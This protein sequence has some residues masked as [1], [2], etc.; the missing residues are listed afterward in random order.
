DLQAAQLALAGHGDGDEAAAGAAF[1]EEVADVLLE[2]LHLGLHALQVL[3]H[4]HDVFHS[5]S[6]SSS[7][8]GGSSSS[9][10]AGG[11]RTVI[12]ETR[13]PGKVSRMARTSGSSCAAWRSA[14]WRRISS[15]RTVG[16]SSVVV[17]TLTIQLRPVHCLRR[18]ESVWMMPG[19]APSARAT[20][21]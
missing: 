4:A 19:S 12:L 5:S 10:A 21:M 1:D 18:A 7:G 20:S 15:S 11:S 9:A 17:P 6:S 3:H 2:L 14:S 13:A 8:S 16:T